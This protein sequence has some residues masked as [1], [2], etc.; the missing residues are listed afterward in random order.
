MQQLRGSIHRRA[1]GKF[2]VV[3]EPRPRPNGR[4]SRRSLGTFATRGLAERA[5]AEYNAQTPTMNGRHDSDDLLVADIARRW[6]SKQQLRCEAGMIARQT[7]SGY[8]SIVDVHVISE[9]GHERV[10]ALTPDRLERCQL[11]LHGMSPQHLS[12]AAL[13]QRIEPVQQFDNR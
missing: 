2:T 5:L 7:R 3:T 8:E 1:N 9:L 4:Q 12:C 10:S 6:R 13:S 11:E